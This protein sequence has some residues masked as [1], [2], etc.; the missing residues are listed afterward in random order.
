[1]S[2]RMSSRIS[3]G[4]CDNDPNSREDPGD[5]FQCETGLFPH[6]T[7]DCVSKS[8]QRSKRSLEEAQ[9]AGCVGGIMPH[10]RHASVTVGRSVGRSSQG[11]VGGSSQEW[12]GIVPRQN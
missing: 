9:H 5:T 4:K 11:T 2:S 1:M 10:E 12:R 6:P 7:R 8:I 3:V